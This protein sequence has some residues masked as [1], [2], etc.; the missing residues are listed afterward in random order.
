MFLDDIV[1]RSETREQVGYRVC[2][3]GSAMDLERSG[4]KVFYNR[5]C[6]SEQWNGE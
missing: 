6:V 3:G 5:I 2:K 1:K 4:M